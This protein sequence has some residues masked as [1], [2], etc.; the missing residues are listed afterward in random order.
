MMAPTS[1]I[2]AMVVALVLF[3]LARTVFAATVDISTQGDQ[4][5]SKWVA[6]QN[7][8]GTGD[9]VLGGEE[10]DANIF[11]ITVRNTQNAHPQYDDGNFNGPKCNEGNLS[12]NRPVVMDIRYMDNVTF[13]GGIVNNAI[14]MDSLWGATYNS[15]CNQ[16]TFYLDNADDITVDEWFVGGGI[17]CFRQAK[18]SNRL[19]ISNTYVANCR[20]DTIE[21]DTLRST[22]ITNTFFDGIWQFKSDDPGANDTTSNPAG[23][24]FVMNNVVIYQTEMPSHPGRSTK[25]GGTAWL[26]AY[27]DAYGE[28]VEVD[29]DATVAQQNYNERSDRHTAYMKVE[30][31]SAAVPGDI[32]DV[33]FISEEDTWEC[34][35]NP[36]GAR[37]R[38]WVSELTNV[39]NVYFIHVGTTRSGDP[40]E[41]A[42]AAQDEIAT[43][44]SDWPGEVTIINADGTELEKAQTILATLRQNWFWDCQPDIPRPAGYPASVPANCDSA[45]IT[46][47]LQYTAPDPQDESIPYDLAV[48]SNSVRWKY[49]CD[50]PANSRVL[51]VTS[52][53]A[54]VGTVVGVHRP[55]CDDTTRTYVLATLLPDKVQT[56]NVE[57]RECP[58]SGYYIP[59]QCTTVLETSDDYVWIP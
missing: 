27:W 19:T 47:G 34:V 23:Q 2:S 33:V 44:Q 43:M 11:E 55:T 20:D 26:K 40:T 48:S 6:S 35:T 5:V 39:D 32:T 54:A 18:G 16:A 14:P 45:Y 15:N 38:N 52:T 1:R 58:G 4:G 29:P 42:Q 7:G 9:L 8:I 50:S 51:A 21:N 46:N 36:D 24:T 59:D 28:Y 41:M 22:T 57:A 56:I 12:H 31:A 37:F 13:R 25:C 17:D 3:S 30:S 53:E 10:G 49:K